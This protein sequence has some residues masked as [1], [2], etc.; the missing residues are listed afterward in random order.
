MKIISALILIALCIT[1]L[2]P[3]AVVRVSSGSQ[4]VSIKTLDVCHQTD[5]IV[6]NN[7]DLPFVSEDP[8]AQARLSI[9]N[10]L[11][12]SDSATQLPLITIPIE[13]PP[14]V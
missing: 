3:L 14:K 6:L 12:P 4:A 8:C 2:S 1:S 5:S 9:A 11:Y 13:L 7:P 10:F